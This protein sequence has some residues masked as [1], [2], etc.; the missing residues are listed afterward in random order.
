M[1]ICLGGK[2]VA[3]GEAEAAAQQRMPVAEKNKFTLAWQKQSKTRQTKQNTPSSQHAT[4][5]NN[6]KHKALNRILVTPICIMLFMLLG[7]KKLLRVWVEISTF[8]E[9]GGVTPELLKCPVSYS[10]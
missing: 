6:Q 1:E 4:I 10:C 2:R 9:G 5:E 3:N 7:Y 8:L